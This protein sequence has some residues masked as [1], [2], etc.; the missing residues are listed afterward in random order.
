MCIIYAY[1]KR[2]CAYLNLTLLRRLHVSVYCCFRYQML[3]K[4]L[5]TVLFFFLFE[6][7][8]TYRPGVK[9]MDSAH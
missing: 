6:E 4:N 7:P 8:K 5:S 1:I 2:A 3:R 9:H